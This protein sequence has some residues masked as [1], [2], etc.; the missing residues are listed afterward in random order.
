M[1][2]SP[3]I[4]TGENASTL[5]CRSTLARELGFEER[6]STDP[7]RLWMPAEKLG[8]T[9][10][11]VKFAFPACTRTFL[12]DMGMPAGGGA[13]VLA[14]VGFAARA[15]A[16]ALAADELAARGAAG[17]LGEGAVS[18]CGPGPLS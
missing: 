13:A 3:V 10:K 1:F 14:T 12:I 5:P 9:D 2:T 15:S 17:A 7:S 16:P 6:P 4:D 8:A 11:S 18:A